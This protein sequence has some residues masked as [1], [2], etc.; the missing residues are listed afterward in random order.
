MRQSMIFLLYLRYV[1]Y[2]SADYKDSSVVELLEDRDKLIAWLAEE[3]IGGTIKGKFNSLWQ[4]FY[5]IV[6][7]ASS[8][9][10]YKG[11]L[12][13]KQL[14]VTIHICHD[15]IG[16]THINHITLDSER[17]CTGVNFST[18]KW[19]SI[20]VII[21]LSVDEECFVAR[22]QKPLVWNFPKEIRPDG[23]SVTYEMVSQI[24]Y[25]NNHFNTCFA[26]DKKIYEYDGMKGGVGK[27]LLNSSLGTELYGQ[28][29]P[30]VLSYKGDGL[31]FEVN[32]PWFSQKIKD[33]TN[34]YSRVIS[35]PQEDN[36]SLPPQNKP[37]TDE[38][39]EPDEDTYY[40]DIEAVLPEDVVLEDETVNAETVLPKDTILL[41]SD[42]P[43]NCRCGAAGNGL[44]LKAEPSEAIQCSTSKKVCF[45]CDFCSNGKPYATPDPLK[46]WP[47]RALQNCL[48]VGRGA[49]ILV[50]HYW[51]PGRILRKAK[52]SGVTTWDVK[53]WRDVK[54]TGIVDELWGDVNGWQAIQLGCWKLAINAPSEKDIIE[55]FLEAPITEEI[56]EVLHCHIIILEDLLNVN[57]QTVDLRKYR[58]VP[59]LAYACRMEKNPKEQSPGYIQGT[60]EHYG[61]LTPH[62]KA[63]ITHWFSINIPLASPGKKK[64]LNKHPSKWML[65]V[66]FVHAVT[67]YIAS[68]YKDRL[69]SG[70][71]SIEAA[72]E[73]Q[74]LFESSIKAGR[75]GSGIWGLDVGPLQDEWYPYNEVPT[76]WQDPNFQDL[77][78]DLELNSLALTIRKNS[79]QAGLACP[80]YDPNGHH[81]AV[82]L[83][84]FPRFTHVLHDNTLYYDLYSLIY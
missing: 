8:G 83:E 40:L 69:G 58:N 37:T 53:L 5:D 61:D 60:I 34:K 22:H 19:L 43:F 82:H 44:E 9:I 41:E 1:S 23:N 64:A 25:G 70:K 7:E 20:P 67:L 18:T 42:S 48:L 52:E 6:D 79:E 36:R 77:A 14:E 17:M 54:D 81:C 12:Y 65:T 84:L 33:S 32:R 13:F 46:G 59:A 4:W 27:K 2:Q 11:H 76:Y 10:R 66:S 72:W 55:D 35:W 39:V 63:A 71:K 15:S 24:F 56:D 49:L 30:P 50:G 3:K 73:Y 16:E 28:H 47:K 29:F 21:M 78:D 38:T 75:T 31:S 68:V 74:R 57:L 80:K 26:Y 51:Y 62:K 45:T